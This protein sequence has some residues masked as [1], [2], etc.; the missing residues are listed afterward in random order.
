M[1]TGGSGVALEIFFSS[2]RRHTR[3]L[4]DWSSDVCSSDL[5][6][7]RGRLVVRATRPS[8]S[9]EMAMMIWRA[10][11]VS[12]EVAGS[13]RGCVKVQKAVY[14]VARA[15]EQ[16]GRASCRERGGSAVGGGTSEQEDW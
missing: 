2:R 3:S 12:C 15:V 7:G 14:L 4:C 13:G 5:G 1:G 8:S 6:T 10:M 9:A 16:I 11:V